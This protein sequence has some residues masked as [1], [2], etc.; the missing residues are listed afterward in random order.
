VQDF[1]QAT[2]DQH[3]QALSQDL[4]PEQQEQFTRRVKERALQSDVTLTP[5]AIDGAA[6]LLSLAAQDDVDLPGLPENGRISG[7]LGHLTLPDVSLGGVGD[8]ASSV[9]GTAKDGL[10]GLLGGA[11]NLIGK[12]GDVVSSA[13]SAASGAIDLAGSAGSAIG[14]VAGG[15]AGSAGDIVGS[16]GEILGAAGDVAGIILGALGDVLGDL[17][18]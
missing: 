5:D 10:G 16:S 12:S 7:L 17:D 14:D 15:V 1:N 13:G 6:G 11:I 18:F 4:S 9:F 2:L 3:L 8:L